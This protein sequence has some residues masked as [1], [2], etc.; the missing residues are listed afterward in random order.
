MLA[1]KLCT[2]TNVLRAVV[3]I[4]AIAVLSQLTT[5]FDKHFQAVAVPSL[6]GGPDVVTVVGC[7]KNYAAFVTYNMDLYFN[8]YYWFRVIFIYLFPCSTLV[9]LNAL[10]VRTMRQAA[11]RRRQLLAQN[12]KSECRR[13]PCRR[14]AVADERLETT[15]D[16]VGRIVELDDAG[17]DGARQDDDGRPSS[18]RSVCVSDVSTGAGSRSVVGWPSGT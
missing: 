13:R 15:R 7:V 3:V 4:Y 14:N 5:F 9:V 11:R 10:L 18:R 1:K 6:V 8:V 17:D 12:R 16:I 2:I